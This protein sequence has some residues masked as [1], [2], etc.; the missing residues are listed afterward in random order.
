MS[1]CRTSTPVESFASGGTAR[2]WQ[3]FGLLLLNAVPLVLTL[4]AIAIFSWVPFRWPI[5]V[6]G[7]VSF[8]Y[9]APP[10]TG[11][12]LCAYSPISE[13]HVAIGS[14]AFTTWWALL[15]LQLIFC[16]LPILAEALRIV[17]GL[18]SGWL[19][20][21]GARIGRLT[22]WS[23]GV[24]IL[25]R[26]F[27]HVGRDVVIGAGV[28]LSSHLFAARPEGGRELLLGTIHIGDDACVGGYSVLG[29]GA[30][31]EPGASTRACLRALAVR[32]AG[33]QAREKRRLQ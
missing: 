16:R 6:A 29:P 32:D 26:P 19:R 2:G 28:S 18:Y 13:G 3:R 27:V 21:W 25:D 12:V 31:I 4:G 5:R 1:E 15:Q 24:S 23:P 8:L 20:L 14:R 17:P 30:R 22:F 10:I 11:R 33:S 7:A 9:L